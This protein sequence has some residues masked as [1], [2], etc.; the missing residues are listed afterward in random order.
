MWRFAIISQPFEHLVFRVGPLTSSKM[1]GTQQAPKIHLLTEL[2]S[3]DKY[4][5]KKI[6][7][8]LPLQCVFHIVLTY[9]ATPYVFPISWCQHDVLTHQIKSVPS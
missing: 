1:S 2:K 5:D 3:M 7:E 4:S 6:N 9:L 8:S